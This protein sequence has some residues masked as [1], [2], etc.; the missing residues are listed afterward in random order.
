MH[1]ESKDQRRQNLNLK[2]IQNNHNRAERMRNRVP[3]L[4]NQNAAKLRNALSA[5]P[6]QQ[7]LKKQ[8]GPTRTTAVGKP[9]IGSG[10]RSAFQP[11]GRKG[12]KRTSDR[13]GLPEE[14]KKVSRST[15]SNMYSPTVPNR[16]QR[17]S[18]A[19]SRKLTNP[20]ASAI[21][22]RYKELNSKL[23]ARQ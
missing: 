19:G 1:D 18:V 9:N 23:R 10:E 6:P 21:E 14:E 16:Q 3:P 2:V 7:R 5:S 22:K 15:T 12:I 17:T 8:V 13:T 20:P 11:V 4:V